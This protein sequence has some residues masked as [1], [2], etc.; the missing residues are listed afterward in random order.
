MSHA[1]NPRLHKARWTGIACLC[2]MAGLSSV[3]NCE[4]ATGRSFIGPHEYALPANVPDGFSAFLVYGYFESAD[5]IYDAG[6][7]KNDADRTETLVTL[8]KFTHGWTLESN[9]NLGL[10]WE[11]ILPWSGVRNFSTDSSASGIGDPIAAPYV[12][13]QLNEHVT[14]GTDLLI[15]A[16]LGDREAGGGD[17][18]KVINSV[19]ADVKYGKFDYTGDI[20]W[21]YPGESVRDETKS[22]KSWSTENIFSYRVTELLEPYVGVAYE[23]QKSTSS[24]LSNEETDV[25]GGLMVHFKRGSVGAHY[26]QVVDGKNRPASNSVNMRFVWFL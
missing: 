17:R 11:V 24:N 6:G 15:Q 7:H 13:Y 16:P 26:A 21:N 8:T 1:V 23:R 18:W 3:S 25:L 10:A 14:V 19:F 22:G 5:E 9:P 12:W 4:A 20:I 2:G